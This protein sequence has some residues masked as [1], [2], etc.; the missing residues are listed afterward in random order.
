ML[1][2]HK[3]RQRIVDTVVANQVTIVV[4]ETGSG[5]TTQ[6]PQYLYG[7]SF[8]T[9]DGTIGIT[10]PRRIAAT[11]VARFVAGQLGT[12]LGD[13]VGYQIRFDDRTVHYDTKIKFMTDGILLREFQVDPDLSRYSVIMIDE[14]HERSVNIDFTLGLLKDLLS[15]RPDLKVVIS[16]ATIDTEKFSRYFDGAPIIEV[17]GRTYP[18]D[19]VWSDKNYSEWEIVDAVVEQIVKI[20][21]TMD[22]GSVLVFMT[23]ADDIGKVVEALEEKAVRQLGFKDLEILRAHG[24]LSS[25]ELGR[26]F[27]DIPGKRKIIVA[28]NI[29]ETSITVEGRIYVVD[30][31]RI[32]QTHFN[33]ESG[34]QSLDVVEHSQAGCNQ[35]AGRAGRTEAGMCF[36]MFTEENFCERPEYTEPE[37]RRMSLA[38]V[39]LSMEDIGIENIKN[40][41]FIDPPKKDAFHEAYQTLIALGAVVADKSG[42]TALGR[43]MA[44][45]PLEP[46][47]A[48]MVL[49]AEKHGCIKEIA[50]VA[51]FMSVRTI[52][53]RP[54]GKEMDADIAHMRFKN[55]RSDA[56]TFLNVWNAYE[57]SGYDRE[58]CFKNF[59]RSRSLWEVKNIRSQIISILR[60]RGEVTSN[61]DENIILRSVAAGL[62]MNL[63]EHSSRHEYNGQLQNLNSVY[64]FP[65]SAVFGY[66]DPHWIVATEI[67][68][69]S[70]SFARGVSEVDVRWLPELAPN[71]FFVG[72]P[73]LTSYVDGE[74]TVTARRPIIKKG[75]G[76]ALY[77]DREVGLEE[78]Q[79][80]I[81]EAWRIQQ[82]HVRKAIVDGLIL[83][84]FKEVEGRY[85]ASKMVAYSG[86]LQYRVEIL[87]R[88]RPEVG[89]TYYCTTKP[90]IFGDGK[91]EA[92]PQFVVLDLPEPE[93]GAP[94]N[95][96]SDAPSVDYATRLRQW[97]REGKKS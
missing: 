51:A 8:G 29:A 5:K 90:S 28:T 33:P 79:M 47:I 20:H 81:N 3:Y 32:K 65:G 64:I 70:K 37:I 86:G 60:R 39:V 50:T 59:L 66:G 10:E 58:W 49:E 14:A 30:S 26:I 41:D 78:F 84:V 93:S 21:T 45:L 18:V 7:A 38:G 17:S 75:T 24:G 53:A 61:P 94:T 9:N 76:S 95:D 22:P 68:R 85:G 35:R 73:Q 13:V 12:K 82:N 15:R 67:M 91:M 1:P 57:D 43:E 87:S 89:K 2:I 77:P 96:S 4:G 97:A 71:H 54:K 31:G 83:L 92:N 56:L 34:I 69:T 74:D 16:S 23:G 62:I 42:L 80:P 27:E 48:R 63:L 36:R 11:S 40:F 55:N 6:L 52:F 88:V 19:I 25:E 72:K 44:R 46:R